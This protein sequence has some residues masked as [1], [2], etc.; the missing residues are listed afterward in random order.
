MK[1]MTLVDAADVMEISVE[2]L[3]NLIRNGQAN[4]V[5]IPGSDNLGYISE[6]EV[7]DLMIG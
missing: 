5:T 1:Y 3:M 6:D 2:R 7:L 4:G